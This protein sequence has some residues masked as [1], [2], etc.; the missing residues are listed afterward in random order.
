MENNF[1]LLSLPQ[2]NASGCQDGQLV[3]KRLMSSPG[4][5]RLLLS[6]PAG[7]GAS[8]P[9]CVKIPNILWYF[10][11]AFL[12]VA[13]VRAQKVQ[14]HPPS[15]G[16]V[17][18]APADLPM[19]LLAP[20]GT[21]SLSI[22]HS[23][24][25]LPISYVCLLFELPSWL[26]QEERISTLL[27]GNQGIEGSGG[28]GIQAAGYP[29][30]AWA[31]LSSSLKVGNTKVPPWKAAGRGWIMVSAMKQR[32]SPAFHEVS[33]YFKNA[34][35]SIRFYPGLTWSMHALAGP[36]IHILWGKENRYL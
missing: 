33:F 13:T 10:E 29:S 16:G 26:A 34:F 19:V 4:R 3:C 15:A 1:T 25:A 5:H 11:D 14:S 23:R 7:K 30:A 24:G 35:P 32:S 20:C 8:A 6:A 36:V 27:W 21:P 31:T 9:L 22:F 18:S 2:R 12:W 17:G 28:M